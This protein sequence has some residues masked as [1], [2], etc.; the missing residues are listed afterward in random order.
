[1]NRS[2]T[3]IGLALACVGL[4]L[5]SSPALGANL[6]V[7]GDFEQGRVGFG[8]DYRNFPGDINPASAFIP[9]W[10]RMKLKRWRR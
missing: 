4:I 9:W 5:S 3:S 2:I 6:V 10:T 1:M 7:N 8:S